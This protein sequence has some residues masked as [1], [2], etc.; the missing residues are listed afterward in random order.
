MLGCEGKIA[1]STIIRALSEQEVELLSARSRVTIREKASL[2]LRNDELL[3]EKRR[4]V[5]SMSLSG[6]RCDTL[7]PKTIIG[8]G[9]R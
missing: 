2:S 4:V 8:T 1:K 5:K 9:R 3:F 7:P 6:R